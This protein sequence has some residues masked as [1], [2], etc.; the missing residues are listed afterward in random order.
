MGDRGCWG[1]FEVAP[2]WDLEVFDDQV[3]VEASNFG[4]FV[5]VGDDAVARVGV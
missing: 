5:D 1:G 3:F 2:G 4:L